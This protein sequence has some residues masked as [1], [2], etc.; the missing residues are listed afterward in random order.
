MICTYQE[1]DERLR[2]IPNVVIAKDFHTNLE[3]DLAL[4]HASLLF[5]GVSSGPTA[6]SLLSGHPFIQFNVQPIHEN[7]KKGSQI[8]FTDE[9]QKIIWEPETTPRLIEEFAS[10]FNKVDKSSWIEIIQ[11][12]FNQ[13][14]DDKSHW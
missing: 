5:M 12:Q 7:I 1:I 6:L 11:N 13:N 2:Q 14:D 4:I 3:E 10:L 8:I 9:L